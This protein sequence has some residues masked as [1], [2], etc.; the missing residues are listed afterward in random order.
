MESQ[1][2]CLF[3]G[4]R[5][6]FISNI[7]E[8]RTALEAEFPGGPGYTV[9]VVKTTN[10]EWQVDVA[11]AV[12]KA[13]VL[14]TVV[15]PDLFCNIG[16]SYALALPRGARI[17]AVSSSEFLEPYPWKPDVLQAGIA[18]DL[19]IAANISCALA[20]YLRR[21]AAGCGG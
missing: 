2:G 18:A 9:D 12:S 15:H 17:L 3:K 20:A 5:M 16:L 21:A 10:D 13:S 4:T 1:D 7:E 19:A 11:A 14:L 6:E 8:L